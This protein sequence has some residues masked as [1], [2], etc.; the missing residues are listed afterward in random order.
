MKVIEKILDVFKTSFFAKALDILNKQLPEK[1]SEKDRL[2]LELKFRELG[3]DFEKTVM[4]YAYKVSRDSIKRNAIMEGT[5][6]DLRGFPVVGRIVLLIRGLQRPIWSFFT[7]YL[8]YNV[9]ADN[10]PLDKQFKLVAFLTI[11]GIVLSVLFGERAI[12]NII[13]FLGKFWKSGE[14]Q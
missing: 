12:I 3:A 9:L 4:E 2:K 5:A 14:K 7:L 10:W 6:R 13:P 1:I 8:D 11:N